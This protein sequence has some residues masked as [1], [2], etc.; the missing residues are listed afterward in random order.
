MAYNTRRK[1]G[2]RRG[3]PVTPAR[4]NHHLQQRPIIEQGVKGVRL[5]DCMMNAHQNVLAMLTR[6]GLKKVKDGNPRLVRIEVG[7]MGFRSDDGWKTHWEFGGPRQKKAEQFISMRG[8]AMD[9]HAWAVYT[10]TEGQEVIIDPYFPDYATYS[11]MWGIKTKDVKGS[12]V[13][14]SLLL[15]NSRANDEQHDALYLAMVIL[16]AKTAPKI[17]RIIKQIGKARRRFS[18]GGDE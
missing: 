1:Q 5:S 18:I 14:H 9:A 10:N 3:K 2:S 8:G 13:F 11:Q 7:S 6:K 16:T 17:E 4:G 12:R 15:R